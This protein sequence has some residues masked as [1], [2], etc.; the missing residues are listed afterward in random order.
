MHSPC[1][2][3]QQR[4]LVHPENYIGKGT[5]RQRRC[6]GIWATP[7]SPVQELTGPHG[8]QR[9]VDAGE[10]EMQVGGVLPCGIV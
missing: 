3:T 5:E 2:Y 6:I 8:S 4:F 10:Q 7:F 1:H 9:G